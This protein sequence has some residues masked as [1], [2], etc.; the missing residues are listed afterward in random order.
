MV[1]RVLKAFGLT[2]L[3]FL[4]IPTI[5]AIGV[6]FRIMGESFGYHNGETIGLLFL[7]VFS[8]SYVFIGRTEK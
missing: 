1:N 6:V 5:L 4:G 2:C 3:V 8:A 7:T